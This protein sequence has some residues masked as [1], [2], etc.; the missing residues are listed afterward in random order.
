MSR[1]PLSKRISRWPLRKLIVMKYTEWP[2]ARMCDWSI[3]YHPGSTQL[4]GMH[5]GCP[6]VAA[7]WQSTVSSRKVSWFDSLWLPTFSL[8][9]FYNSLY[10]YFQC[11]TRCFKH[12]PVLWYFITHCRSIY[13]SSHLQMLCSPSAQVLLWGLLLWSLVLLHLLLD[14]WLGF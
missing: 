11:E 8:F 14:F 1:N 13:Y 12:N 3:Q 9:S 7:Q 4:W 6:L 2:A 10:F 5:G